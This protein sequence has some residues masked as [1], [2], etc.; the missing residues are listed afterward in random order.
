MSDDVN[1]LDQVRKEDIKFVQFQFVDIHG[2]IKSR[3]APVEALPV[4][5]QEGVPFDG[6]SIPGFVTIEQ[7]DLVARPDLS[8][9]TVL[10]WADGP[11]KSA[12]F[13]CDV[14]NP[15]D[16]A[17][18]GDPRYLLRKALREAGDRGFRVYAGPEVEFCLFQ[19]NGSEP[20][21]TGAYMDYLPS[22][23]GEGFKEELIINI[24]R[25]GI[26]SEIA[27]HETAPGQN[28]VTFRYQ[29]ALKAADNVISFRLAVRILAHSKGLKATF[30]PKPIFGAGANGMHVH[31]SLADKETGRN[32]FFDG[33][34]AEGLSDQCRYFIGGL[35]GHARGM[36]AVGACTVNSYKRLVPGLEAPVY[37]CWGRG[38]RSVLVRVPN[39]YPKEE[40][41]TRAEYRGSDGSGNPYLV[42]AM[43]IRAGLEGIDK[44]HDP[45]KPIQ[46]NVY[47]FTAYDMRKHRIASL[48]GTLGEALDEL[49]KDLTIQSALGPHTYAAFH[50][51]KMKEWN[52][53]LE[54]ISREGDPGIRIS[55]WEMA[56][57]FKAF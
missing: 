22:D 46:E 50:G 5:L 36:S 53:Y 55:P 25:M 51:I 57:Y 34:S 21:D 14:F 47:R 20:L 44:N 33:N 45:G 1:I 16:T 39:Y 18:E 10:P 29:E 23:A 48:P 11:G 35:L 31:M 27:H 7:S 40:K 8:T 30:M 15:D 41:S 9:F 43:M 2:S 49:K 42:M 12:R 28:E 13:I 24:K 3:V 6:S 37:I 26:E 56:R 4:I 52:E 19:S 17:F 38:N 54:V 32:V